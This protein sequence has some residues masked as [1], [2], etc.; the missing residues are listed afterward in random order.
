MILSLRAL[1]LSVTICVTL[2]E[3]E[4]VQSPLVR[5]RAEQPSLPHQWLPGH[6]REA[7]SSGTDWDRG[8]TFR[9][10]CRGWGRRKSDPT[11]PERPGHNRLETRDTLSP[12]Q[13]GAL[14][15]EQEVAVS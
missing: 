12:R 1:S 4:S 13:R 2:L 14:G 15:Q 5:G 9:C 3:T 7:N 11:T 10:M 6:S 8:K